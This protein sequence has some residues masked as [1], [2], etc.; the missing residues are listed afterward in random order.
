MSEC[1]CTFSF[2]YVYK[3]YTWMSVIVYVLICT[4][5]CSRVCK[6]YA[7]A[8]MYPH[9]YTCQCKWMIHIWF[10]ECGWWALKVGLNYRHSSYIGNMDVVT[11]EGK[12]QE[13]KVCP[14]WFQM[15]RKAQKQLFEKTKFSWFF[16]YFFEFF[17][18]VI[19]L[20]EKK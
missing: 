6:R 2:H 10:S 18:A 8:C 4:S 14:K 3:L 11:V 20:W 5:V 15:I 1:P 9:I 17:E 19:T 12:N 16:A 13:K 7:N